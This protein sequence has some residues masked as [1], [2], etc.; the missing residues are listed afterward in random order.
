M[1]QLHQCGCSENLR[2]RPPVPNHADRADVVVSGGGLS[3]E[4]AKK[5]MQNDMIET[6][7]YVA[8]AQA[9][10]IRFAEKALF[11]AIADWRSE[12]PPSVPECAEVTR[13]DAFYAVQFACYRANTVMADDRYDLKAARKLAV[14]LVLFEQEIPL[15]KLAALA[16][17]YADWHK[18]VLDYR[19]AK[20]HLAKNGQ[21]NGEL[22]QKEAIQYPLSGALLAR[23][24]ALTLQ[25]GLHLL[26][27]HPTKDWIA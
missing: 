9:M 17:V 16:Q 6:A 3:P 26:N 19:A 14:A 13:D 25:N 8:Q 12:T 20:I 1:Q 18:T 4:I 11:S 2:I 27:I 10:N 22:T 5:L 24:T 7:E 23:A 21:T 15:Q